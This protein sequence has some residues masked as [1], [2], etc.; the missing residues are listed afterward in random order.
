M[1]T[2]KQTNAGEN[3]TCAKSGSGKYVNTKL[4]DLKLFTSKPKGAV[5]LNH[6]RVG[7]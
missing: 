7:D 4:T 1:T 3:S 2:N 6:T 5:E